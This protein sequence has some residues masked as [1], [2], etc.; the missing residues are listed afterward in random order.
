ML[1]RG[2]NVSSN[3]TRSNKKR[4]RVIRLNSL[5]SWPKVVG[6]NPTPVNV[7][8]MILKKRKKEI[9]STISRKLKKRN[10]KLFFIFTLNSSFYSKSLKYSLLKY[11]VM[12]YNMNL[13]RKIINEL[14]KEEIGFVFGLNN[15]FYYYYKKL[16]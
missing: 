4:D 7:E 16:Y 15:W 3:L 11:F 10:K 2:I 13:N 8:I 14:Y 1:F 6:S 5:G 12:K 9:T